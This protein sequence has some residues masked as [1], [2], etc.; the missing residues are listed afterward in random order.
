MNDS[1]LKRPEIGL[2]LI[3]F[4]HGRQHF[5]KTMPSNILI[6]GLKKKK[7][8]QNLALQARV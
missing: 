3:N 6:F 2:F 5:G 1:H 8:P 7:Q 4:L